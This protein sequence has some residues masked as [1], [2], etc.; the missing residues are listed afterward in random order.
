MTLVGTRTT[1]DARIH[2]DLQGPI[3][4]EQL[5]HLVERN[6]LPVLHQ[7]TR[8]TQRRLVLRLC[9]KRPTVGHCVW[10]HDRYADPFFQGRGFE[11]RF[12]HG[13]RLGLCAVGAL[14][15]LGQ[16]LRPRCNVTVFTRVIPHVASR[17]EENTWRMQ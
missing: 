3:S 5:T 8:K 16:V 4:P 17:A 6:L 7:F 14:C 13:L 15:T 11:F 2:E 1:L 9:D 10:L 12:G